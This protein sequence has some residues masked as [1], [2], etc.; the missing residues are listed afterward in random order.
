MKH[1]KVIIPLIMLFL[2]A[3]VLYITF[4]TFENFIRGALF[5]DFPAHIQVSLEGLGYSLM[6]FIIKMV[7]LF[8][9]S[10][11]LLSLV[12]SAMTVM[13]AVLTAVLINTV[14][15][16]LSGSSKTKLSIE[17]YAFFYLISLSL[18]FSA[19]I[20]IPYFWPHIYFNGSIATQP[21]HNST[22]SIMRLFATPTVIYYFKIETTY[23]KNGF[24]IKELLLFT[25]FLSLVNF[26]KPNFILTF[27]V[28][29]LLMLIFDFLRSKGKSF[30]KALLFGS[31]VIVSL[32]PVL[33]QYG[34]LFN[35]ESG[36]SVSVNFSLLTQRLFSKTFPFLLISN[37]LFPIVSTIIILVYKH[38]SKETL[39]TRILAEG[40]LFSLVSFLQSNV[41]SETGLRA[42]HGNFTWGE[43]YFSLLLFIICF[44]YI[45]KIALDNKKYYFSLLLY[46]PHFVTGVLYFLFI[47]GYMGNFNDCII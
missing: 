9:N 16:L 34:V 32:V 7:Y 29:M 40:W 2:T 5:S 15:N 43:K 28:A 37:F 8:K 20:Y 23:L 18:L 31:C 46:M 44:S 3:S 11:V 4:F 25:V 22:Y 45:I 1:K 42:N 38:T 24:S 12:M 33:F 47:N 6:H 13:T 21:W 36:S 10:E 41:L 39:S 35:E 30:F 27:G 14:I 19:S 17:N 26:A